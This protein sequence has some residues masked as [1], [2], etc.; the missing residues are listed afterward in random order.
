M[1]TQERFDFFRGQPKAKGIPCERIASY[2]RDFKGKDNAIPINVVARAFCIEEKDKTCPAMRRRIK[3]TIEEC[4]APIG[5]CTHGFYWIVSDE[6]LAENLD[7]LNNRITGTLK[8]IR[9]L[10]RAFAFGTRR[11]NA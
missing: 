4:L 7:N 6:E 8:K 2:M 1:Q 9:I 3:D 10:R 11:P 5:S